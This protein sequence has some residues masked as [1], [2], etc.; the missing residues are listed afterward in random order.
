MTSDVP[1]MRLAGQLV[2]LV[3]GAEVPVEEIAV[4]P[5]MIEAGRLELW[6][7]VHIADRL[8]GQAGSEELV[9]AIWSAME[10]ARRAELVPLSVSE[11]SDRSPSVQAR[12]AISESVKRLIN[13]CRKW[14]GGLEDDGWTE[15]DI[16]SMARPGLHDIIL[17]MDEIDRP[18]GYR[19]ASEDEP[20]R[21]G[22]AGM[23]R[24]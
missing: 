11:P 6:G 13:A 1:N 22:D 8:Q 21:A 17:A 7:R 24:G 12:D 16:R 14:R 15:A 5:A 18:P 10:R 3:S 4:T 9:G 19:S 2:D 20:E 23:R